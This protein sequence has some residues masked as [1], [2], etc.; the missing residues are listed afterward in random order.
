MAEQKKS[1]PI[2]KIELRGHRYSLWPDGV[3]TTG[4]DHRYSGMRLAKPHSER[5]LKERVIREEIARLR[6]EL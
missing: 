3:I 1:E 2:H 4:D 6:K 5:R